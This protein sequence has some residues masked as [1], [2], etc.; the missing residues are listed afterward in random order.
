MRD[1]RNSQTTRGLGVRLTDLTDLE[2]AKTLEE[3]VKRL[4]KSGWTLPMYMTMELM[5]EIA[6]CTDDEIDEHFAEFYDNAQVFRRL[7]RDL[8]TSERLADWRQ[9]LE[10]CF[11]NYEGGKH[12]ICIPALLSILEGG[13][14]LADGATFVNADQRIEYFKQKI[15]TYDPESL[16]RLMWKSMNTFFSLLYR[17]RD[18][19]KE[20]PPNLNRHW[21]LHGRDLP[22]EWRRADALRLFNGL[23]TLNSLP[24]I[25]PA[26]RNARR[27]QPS[28]SHS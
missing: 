16:R 19:A 18:F 15:S 1:G 25:Q 27:R 12:L 9:L 23:L 17:K 26:P 24:L 5:V 20:R 11:E 4:A 14:V 2:L 13:L 10:Q 22:S 7:K 28:A 3:A 21:I 6:Q 8:L